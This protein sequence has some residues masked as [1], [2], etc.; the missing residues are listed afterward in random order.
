VPSPELSAADVPFRGP[1]R[2]RLERAV[3]PEYLARQ[4]WFGG[5]A[6]RVALVRF[7]DWAELAHRGPGRTFLA[8]VEVTFDGGGGDLYA[9]PLGVAA[10]Q[11]TAPADAVIAQLDEA[12][13]GAVLYDPLA[14]DAACAALLDA[15]GGGRAIPTQ[16]GRI[17]AFATSAFAGLRGDPAVPLA[18]KRG[19]PTSSNSLV[20]YGG[21]LLLK[22]FRRLEEGVNPD[23][24]IGRFLTEKTSFRQTPLVAGTVE[25]QRPGSGPVTLAILQELVHSEADGWQHALDEL[26][27]YFRRAAVGGPEAIGAYLDAA[28]TLGRRTAELH[29]TLASDATDPAFAP[30]PLT[31]ADLAAVAAD[32]AEQGRKALTALRDAG[33]R[34]TGEVAAAARRF[35]ERAPGVLEGLGRGT[36]GRPAALKTRVHGDYHLGQTLWT[37]GDYVLLDF[38]G[39]P[40][41]SIAE[42]RAKQSPLKDVAGLLRSYNYAANAGLFA[43]A[44]GRPG[45][46]ERLTPWAE[47]WHRGTSAAFLRAYREAAGDAPFLPGDPNEFAELLDLFVLDKALYEL[48][49]ELNNRPDWVRIPLAGVLALIDRRR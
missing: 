32:A 4:R 17:R 9:L 24:E 36:G 3:L 6:R 48:V 14:D 22:V 5:K 47:A 13:G 10:G 44:E 40:A 25:Y 49:Y 19:P 15:I 31:E 46:F 18:V 27:G 37:G 34:L 33:G 11:G 38:E 45:E 21:R 16:A 39:E 30:E 41:R 35:Q 42:R 43:H 28:A 1:A 2:A 12:G 23:F 20:F 8:F 29:R 7:A 26:A